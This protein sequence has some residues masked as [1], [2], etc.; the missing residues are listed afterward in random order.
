MADAIVSTVLEQ[1][2]SFT[3]GEVQHGVGLVMGAGKAV[4]NITST[5]QSIQAL[6]RDAENRQVRDGTVRVWL[7]KLKETSYDMVDVLDEWNTSMQKL[8]MEGVDDNAPTFKKKVCV[9]FLSPRFYF[10]RV[11]LRYKIAL[12]MIDTNEKLD[13]IAKEK[14]RYNFKMIMDVEEPHRVKTTSLRHI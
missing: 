7:D 12:K 9:F 14:E 2:A 3:V 10:R 5:L 6:L 4:E 8:Q 1:L 11:L 13:A